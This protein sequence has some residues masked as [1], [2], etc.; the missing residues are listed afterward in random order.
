MW[1]AACSLN[2]WPE[3]L[4][5]G[6]IAVLNSLIGSLRNGTLLVSLY[7]SL[8]RIVIG[9]GISLAGGVITGLLVGR[10]A[11]LHDTIGSIMLG[12]QTLPSICWLPLALLWFGLSE[13]AILFVIIMGAFVAVAVSTEAGVR[14]I[15][16][17]YLQAA[18][19]MGARGYRLYRDVIIP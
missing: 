19:N 1:Q 4:F 2:I 5:P 14:Q 12:L 3:Y 17:L 18:R 11:L 9:F 13:R 6:P 10:S 7:T 8:R 15:P 16:P